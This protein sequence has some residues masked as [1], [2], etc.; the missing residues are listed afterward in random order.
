MCPGV[1]HEQFKKNI[2][3]VFCC[4]FYVFLRRLIFFIS[5]I[6]LSFRGHNQFRTTWLRK[7]SLKTKTGRD[8]VTVPNL[9][10]VNRLEEQLPECFAKKCSCSTEKLE[11]LF[12]FC[13]Q[14]VFGAPWPPPEKLHH[15]NTIPLALLLLLKDISLIITQSRSTTVQCNHQHSVGCDSDYVLP[16][17]PH[18]ARRACSFHFLSDD[19]VEVLVKGDAG[20]LFLRC[21]NVRFLRL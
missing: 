1:F 5:F 14:N 16:G 9:F 3:H 10:A 11:K 13:Q 18:A 7:T 20:V 21:R 4:S 12:D 8:F 2:F 15:F 19:A 6:C 17:P